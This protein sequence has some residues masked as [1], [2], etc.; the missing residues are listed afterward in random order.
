MP[1]NVESKAASSK[2]AEA[3]APSLLAH[4]S[5]QLSRVTVDAYN[6]DMRTADGFVGDRA[7]KRA[8]Y[9]STG[10]W[11]ELV[12]PG[13]AFP[14]FGRD[15]LIFQQTVDIRLGLCLA[16][17]GSCDLPSSFD[18]PRFDVFGFFGFEGTSMA[19]PH[20][21]GLAALLMQQGITSP[22]AI[23]AAMEKFAKDLGTAGR[24][25]E[26]GFG[27]IQARDTLRG[28]GLAR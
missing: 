11:I 13:G 2:T 4:G 22:A 1:K 21:S 26:F 18:P 7:S 9:S 3:P 17:P 10:S 27:L 8:F 23:E 19:A 5:D 24:D 6:A 14:T 25:N 12:A 28:L 16:E 20:V 15:G